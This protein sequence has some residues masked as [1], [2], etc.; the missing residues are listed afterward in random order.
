MMLSLT[1]HGAKSYLL[2][3]RVPMLAVSGET[4][5]IITLNTDNYLKKYNKRS[6][7]FTFQD[8]MDFP[9]QKSYFTVISFI[10]HSLQQKVHWIYCT[11]LT[12]LCPGSASYVPIL[13]TFTIFS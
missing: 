1:T 13:T 10:R 3:H 2:L 5:K 12:L 8:E 6:Q 9:S 7:A 4:E 11:M